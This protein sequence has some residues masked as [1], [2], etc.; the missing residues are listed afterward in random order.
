MQSSAPPLL[1]LLR[2]Q[3]QGELLSWLYLH[4]EEKHSVTE[5]AHRL[6]VSISTIQREADRLI[7]HGFLSDTRVGRTRLIHARVDTP[8]FR[9]LADLLAVTYGPIPVLTRQLANLP[10]IAEAFV[11]GS[12]AARYY[13]EPGDVPRDVD[14]LVV[15]SPDADDLFEL[16]EKAAKILGREVHIRPVNPDTWHDPKPTGFIA[17]VKSRPIVE[18]GIRQAAA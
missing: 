18:L 7:K 13:G 4:P 9:P 16:A 3:T 1:P 6:G 2:S 15:G 10:G 11:Y 14:V 5:L 8:S 12:W 17:T